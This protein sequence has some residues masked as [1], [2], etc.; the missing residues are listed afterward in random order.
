LGLVLVFIQ[1][2][3]KLAEGICDLHDRC[4]V[5]GIYKLLILWVIFVL[6]DHLGI[7]ERKNSLLNAL[8]EELFIPGILPVV[9]RSIVTLVQGDCEEGILEAS[10]DDVNVAGKELLVNVPVKVLMQD[11]SGILEGLPRVL[12]LVTDKH[13]N[14]S[15]EVL[16]SSNTLPSFSSRAI[17]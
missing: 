16:V 8:C 9:Y 10:S 7:R 17:L 11:G 14:S 3:N 1:V 6:G 4:V 2:V 5:G 12:V 15:T 13:Q